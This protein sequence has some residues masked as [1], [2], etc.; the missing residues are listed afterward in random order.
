MDKNLYKWSAAAYIY[1]KTQHLFTTW[2]YL[3]SEGVKAKSYAWLP[4]EN[5]NKH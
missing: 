2:K 5:L 1:S 3:F 4:G